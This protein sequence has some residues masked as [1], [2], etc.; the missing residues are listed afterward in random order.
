MV[1]I[2]EFE[3]EEGSKPL[4]NE[5]EGRRGSTHETTSHWGGVHQGNGDDG[6]Y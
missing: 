2:L 6:R 5:N 4:G 1:Y 3:E